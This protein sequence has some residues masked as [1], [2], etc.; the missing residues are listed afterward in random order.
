MTTWRSLPFGRHELAESPRW[1]ARTG[2]LV[3]VDVFAG[4]LARAGFGPDA[5]PPDRWASPAPLTA[6][7]PRTDPADGWTVA[8]GTG[9]AVVDRTGRR[10]PWLDLLGPGDA[11][12]RTNDMVAGSDGKVYV[13]LLDEARARP[14]ARVLRVDADGSVAVAVSGLIASNGLGFSPDERTLYVVDSIPRTLSAHPHE[15]RTGAVGPA[16]VIATWPGPGTFDGL[17]VTPSGDLWIAI[18]DGSTVCRYSPDG[19]LL[20]TIPV[21]V[22]RPTAVALVPD[23]LV[24]TSA[25]LGTDGDLDGA[26]L[27]NVAASE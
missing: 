21:P 15:P 10:R 7:A 22:R 18:W 6:V 16:R 8:T 9:L 4:T 26:L 24:L 5:G 17:A 3:W 13:G 12:L 2:E 20:E 27:T 25:R 1:D 23:G 14:R 19:D 11:G